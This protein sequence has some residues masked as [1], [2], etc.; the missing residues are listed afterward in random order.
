MLDRWLISFSLGC[1]PFASYAQATSTE[2]VD[3]YAQ[4]IYKTSRPV[5]MALVVIDGPGAFQRYLGETRYR[6]H[7]PPQADTLFRLA[8]LS[9]IMTSEVLIALAND[10]KLNI[11]D[12]LQQFAPPGVVIPEAKYGGPITLLNLATH[13]SGMPR[14]IP[15]ARP[16]NTPVFTFPTEAERWQWITHGRI[17]NAAGSRAAYSNLGYDFLAD[18]LAQA[19]GKPY[20]RLF[21]EKITDPLG[22]QDTTFSPT[23]AQCARLMQGID[24]SPCVNTLAADGSGGVYSTG[25]DIQLWLQSM[26]QPKTPQIA[27]M[28]AGTCQLYFKRASLRT[29][30]GM[31]HAGKADALGLAWVYMGPKKGLPAMYQKTGGG[32]GY[33]TYIAINPQNKVAIFVAMARG[34]HISPRVMIHQANLLLA[35][36]VAKR[37]SIHASI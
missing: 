6:N 22:M 11:R 34:T 13:T 18:A 9:K 30:V 2:L 15:L 36:L 16:A 37:Q 8:S 3:Q 14:E 24:A 17:Y 31:D 1:L 21:R 19:G 35:Q 32:G 25:H 4:R 27:Q 29:M 26:L 23:A 10:H 12:P 20:S 7:I 33:L 28:V 5:G